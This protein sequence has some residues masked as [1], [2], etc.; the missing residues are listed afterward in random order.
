MCFHKCCKVFQPHWGNNA[1]D[2][3]PLSE[4]TPTMPTGI[5]FISWLKYFPLKFIAGGTDMHDALIRTTLVGVSHFSADAIIPT[6]LDP[7]LAKGFGGLIDTVDN[8]DSSILNNL[9]GVNLNI[10]KWSSSKSTIHFIWTLLKSLCQPDETN[11]VWC[12]YC[13]I[14][15]ARWKAM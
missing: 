12:S 9:S 8:P 4:V 6:C 3:Q 15:M 2:I 7:I 11:L 14:L 13:Q 5:C 10:L 1:S